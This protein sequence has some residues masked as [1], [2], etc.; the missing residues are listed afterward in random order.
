[1]TRLFQN[2]LVA[3][4]VGLHAAVTLCGPGLHAL[5]GWSHNSGLTAL[6]RHD[7]SHGAGPSS[8]QASD[9]CPVCQFLAQGQLAPELAIGVI[10]H[11]HPDLT[12]RVVSDVNPCPPLR[13]F[14]PRGP[15]SHHFLP[16]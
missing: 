13:P 16:I 9:E 6:A 15:P 10:V 2:A 11:I 4:L 3:A 5:P 12:T 8:H 1:M 14:I 7:H